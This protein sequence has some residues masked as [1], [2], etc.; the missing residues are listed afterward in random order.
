MAQHKDG[1]VPASSEGLIA[2]GRDSYVEVGKWYWVKE[3]GH[4]WLGCAMEIGSNFVLIQGPPDKRGYL[5]DRIHFKDVFERLRLEP[6]VAHVIQKKIQHYQSLV[7]NHL[8]EVRMITARLGVAPQSE[9]ASELTDETTS[10]LAVLSGQDNVNAYRDSLMRAKDEELPALFK[11]IE[12]ANIKVA[13]WMGAEILP[14]TAQAN[15][16]KKSF[17]KIE[18]RVF[19]VG[20]YAGLIEQI[21]QCKDGDSAPFHEKLHVMQRMLFMDEECLLNYRVGGM[22]FGDINEFDAWLS[23]PDNRD[24]ILPFPR[25]MVAMRVRR[26]TK[27]RSWNGNIRILLYNI[28]K[29][30]SDKWTF[31]YIRN[32]EQ[33]Y[34]LGSDS[35]E[36]DGARDMLFPDKSGHDLSSPMMV[37]RSSF[38]RCELISVADF[39][40]RCQEEE[41]R[42]LNSEKWIQEH[43][44]ET[45]DGYASTTDEAKR[46]H[47]ALT[48]KW[49]NPYHKDDYDCHFNSK[50]WSP[51]ND[52]YLYF[53][54][55]MREVEDRIK[56]YNRIALL[57]QGL[58]D[59]SNV[60][61][62]HPPVKTWIP[63]SFSAAIELVYDGS[64]SL[65][66]GEK[67]DIEA[68]I[69]ACNA[70]LGQ[71]S[72]VIGQELYWLEK[73]AEKENRRRMKSWRHNDSEPL[74]TFTPS[75]NPGPGYV[76]KIARLKKSSAVFAWNRERL[77]ADY[78][79]GLN[80]GDPIRTTIEVPLSRLFN[81]SAYK[82][83]DFKQFFRDP[84]TRA[85]YLKWAPMLIAAEEFHAGNIKLKDP[86]T[87][88][89]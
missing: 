24:R 42:K 80:Y 15:A 10:A 7:K 49:A 37:K 69:A 33:I 82:Q 4:E 13:K 64:T 41:K 62:P 50:D 56:K 89:L 34:R 22:E 71:D 61:H 11:A 65:Y 66:A 70:N 44:L 12:E 21:V 5:F 83:G 35:F 14:M 1:I 31:L 88:R 54:D 60:L 27:Q 8:E 30:Q 40:V 76:A 39:E 86:V 81:V 2:I 52:D 48:W 72:V 51:F 57:I 32:G 63:E 79:N 23:Q 75:G 85:E 6:S 38:G 16:L 53:D 18:D 67:P 59:R 46:R 28:E 74:E 9:L 45:W 78:F 29:A 17:G 26:N 84:R 20:L 77:V 36:F 68:Y 58:L 73:E 43:P 3:G 55:C 25:C 87:E 19:N 47:L